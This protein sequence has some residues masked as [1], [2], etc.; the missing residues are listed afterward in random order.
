MTGVWGL[1]NANHDT[2]LTADDLRVFLPESTKEELEEIMLEVAP[3]G[4]MSFEEFE[5][6]MKTVD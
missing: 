5:K 3:S 1:I 6:M 2:F 4:K